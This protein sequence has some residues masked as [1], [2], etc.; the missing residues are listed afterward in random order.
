MWNPG[1]GIGRSADREGR[2]VAGLGYPRQYAHPTVASA[3]NDISP[4]ANSTM[5]RAGLACRRE[6]SESLIEQGFRHDC[7]R[8]AVTSRPLE[9][10]WTASGRG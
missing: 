8:R 3:I 9:K 4:I 5:C 2:F 6:E 10:G 7:P 1:P